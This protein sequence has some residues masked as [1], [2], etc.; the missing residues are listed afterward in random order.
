MTPLRQNEQFYTDVALRLIKREKPPVAELKTFLGTKMKTEAERAMRLK[1]QKEDPQFVFTPASV[2]V[3][4]PSQSPA[5]STVMTSQA[6]TSS[7]TATITSSLADGTLLGTITT[8]N[9]PPAVLQRL[10][11][12]VSFSAPLPRSPRTTPVLSMSRMSTRPSRL[13]TPRFHLPPRI[14]R[15]ERIRAP[16]HLLRPPTGA[17]HSTPPKPDEHIVIDD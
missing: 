6:V 7:T 2:P 3:S 4:Q 16:R 12:P 17:R 11:F 15:I 5:T 9:T 1:L 14:I 10:P 13:P 8:C